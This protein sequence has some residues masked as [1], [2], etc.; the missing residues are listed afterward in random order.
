MPFGSTSRRPRAETGARNRRRARMAALAV[1]LGAATMISLAPGAR[2][3]DLTV[4]AAASLKNALDEVAAGFRAETGAA[5]TL[6]YAGSSALARQIEQGAPADLFLSASPD[7]M[8]ALARQG[9]I[10]PA[11]RA[12]LLGN[13]LVLIAPKPS[14]GAPP[15]PFALRNGADLTGRL[16]DGR[17]ALALVDA[18]PAGV[19]AKAALQSLG[20]WSAVAPK[21]AQTDNVRAALALVALGETPLG[22]VYATDAVAEPRV[23]VLA[24]VPAESH[25]PIRYPVAAVAGRANPLTPRFL[26]Y[27]RG[28][29]A[30]AAFERQGFVVLATAAPARKAATASQGD[31]PARAE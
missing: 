27:L 11:S 15:A 16:G 14:D 17:L 29:A 20:L 4:F 18:V 24:P 7:W 28:P 13:R 30:R 2:A 3:A 12:D 31:A 1:W 26:A 25:P 22:I 9:L 19:Y 23:T 5:V 21:T 10:D 6:S 8:D